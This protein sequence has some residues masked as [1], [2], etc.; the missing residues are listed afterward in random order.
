MWEGQVEREAYCL[1]EEGEEEEDGSGEGGGEDW[2]TR[3]KMKERK[4]E[5]DVINVGCRRLE[6]WA[7]GKR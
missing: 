1:E 5:R 7:D 6:E 2:G 3:F 4:K